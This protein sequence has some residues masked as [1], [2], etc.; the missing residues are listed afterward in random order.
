MPIAQQDLVALSRL[1]DEA[2]E[3]SPAQLEP[4]LAAL[5]AEHAHLAAQLRQMLASRT[6]AAE[7]ETPRL[8]TDDSVSH[9]GDRVGPYRLIRE[10]GHGGM[11]A[12]WLAERVDGTLK[13]NVALKLPRL[14]WGQEDTTLPRCSTSYDCG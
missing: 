7:L 8:R 12:V 4:W 10:I 9:G 3:L 1:L 2:M 6:G 5:P 11:G 13:R 14:A